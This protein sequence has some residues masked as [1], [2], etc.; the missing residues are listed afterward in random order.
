MENKP[1]MASDIETILGILDDFAA[2]SESRMK[3]KM[4]ELQAEGTA[5]KVYHHGRCDIGSPWASGECL[6]APEADCDIRK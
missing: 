5:E 1:E 3:L 6:D 2:G 4:S